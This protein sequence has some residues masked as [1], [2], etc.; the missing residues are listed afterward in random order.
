MEIAGIL[1]SLSSQG[2]VEEIIQI[3]EKSTTAEGPI[4]PNNEEELNLWNLPGWEYFLRRGRYQE[5]ERIYR[6]FYDTLL[7]QQETVGR[8]HKGMPLQNLGLSLFFQGHIHDAIKFFMSA[9]IEDAIRGVGSETVEKG[10]AGRV[11]AG[12][13]GVLQ[14]ELLKIRDIT[15]NK[16]SQKIPNRPE[17]ILESKEISPISQE[18]QQRYVANIPETWKWE[19]EGQK[20]LENGNYA[21]S[22][23]IYQNWYSK[24]LEYQTRIGDRVHKG[25]PLFNSG[26]SRFLAGKSDEAFTILLLAY[27]E[28]VVSAFKQGDADDSPAFGLLSASKGLIPDLRRLEA[29]TFQMKRDGED[30]SDPH[31]AV[32]EFLKVEVSAKREFEQQRNDIIAA[33]DKAKGKLKEKLLKA[34]PFDDDSI[35]Y[36]LKKWNSATPRFPHENNEESSGGGYFLQWNKMGII[37]DPGYDFLEHF[38][39]QDFGPSNINLIIVTHAHDDHCQ[40][41]EA[42]F[43]I[44]AKFNRDCRKHEIDLLLSEG[45]HIKYGRLLEINKE[46]IHAEIIQRDPKKV[47][48]TPF[49]ELLQNKYNMTVTTTKT[50]H[51]ERPWMQ[52]NTG[53]GLRITLGKPPN[54]ITIGFTSDTA[55]WDGIGKEFSG[56]DLLVANLGTYGESEFHLCDSGCL[57]LLKTCTPSPKVVIVSEF[58][59]ELKG[60]RVKVCTEIENLAMWQTATDKIQ[61]IAGDVGLKISLPKLGVFCENSGQF[62]DPKMVNDEE[63]N[64]KIRYFRK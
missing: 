48:S 44:L 35:L 30:V 54:S 49:Q 25:H 64:F 1:N 26:Q 13:C 39:N 59:E 12:F 31:E 5:A 47:L 23:S 9:Y 40:D 29:L 43:S 24:L 14:K 18:I 34:K 46:F 32:D 55:F 36:I 62:E 3:L 56:V 38:H 41:L 53:F 4:H 16:I 33:R 15:K 27:V 61:V 51:H 37:I 2:N 63:D 58:G 17:E 19:I 20:A 50:V 60:K 11:L 21:A 6:A 52:N 28:D 42:I 57:D 8:V 22:F 45:T 10:A 7:E